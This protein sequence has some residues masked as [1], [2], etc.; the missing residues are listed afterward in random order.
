MALSVMQVTN[1]QNP[2]SMP[3]IRVGIYETGR[4]EGEK[5]QFSSLVS[6]FSGVLRS[7]ENQRRHEYEPNL[8]V[9]GI[10]IVNVL[11]VCK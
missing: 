11:V 8:D 3:L 9:V 1:V 6:S 2:Y 10:E 7:Q 5:K 4:G